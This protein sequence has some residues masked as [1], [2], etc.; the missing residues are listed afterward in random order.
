MKYSI[1]K[2]LKRFESAL[3]NISRCEDRFEECLALV[4]ENRMYK[5]ALK[6]FLPGSEHFKV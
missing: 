3:V 1:D 4:Q 6:L 5:Q 2:Q